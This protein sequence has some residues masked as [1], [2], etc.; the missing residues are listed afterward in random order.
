MISKQLETA[1]RS[2]LQ[3]ARKRRHE[4]LCAEHVL[5]ALLDDP[6]GRDIL[7]NVGVDIEKL[8]KDLDEYLSRQLD[9]VPERQ[10]LVVQQTVAFDRIMNRALMHAKFSS[11]GE[12]EA[13][14]ALAALLEESQSHAAFFLEEQGVTRLDV[15]N[16][17]SHGVSKVEDA[18]EDD[19]AEAPFGAPESGEADEK[20]NKRDPLELYT[21]NLA[22][23]AAQ[24]KIDPLIG[25]ETELARAVRVLCRRRKNNPVFVGEPGVGKTAIVEGLALRIHGGKVPP[26]LKDAEIFRLDLGALL[27]GTQFRGDLESRIKAVIK[28]LLKRDNV[29]LFI[30]EIH[31]VVGAGSTRG[32]DVDVSGLLKPLLSSGELKCIG[33]T[34]YEEYKNGFEKDRALARRFQKIDV[35]EPT[36]AET[37]QILRGLKS[38]YEAHHGITFTDSALHTAAE[39]AAKYVNDRFLPDKAIDVIDEAGAQVRIESHDQRKTIR[40]ADI[41]RIVA[42]M[43]RIPARS[44]SSNDK[45]RL[46]KLEDDLKQVVYGQ[47]DAVHSIATAIKRSRAGLSLPDKPVGSFLFTGPTG[48]GKTELAK[49]LASTLGID[50]IRFDMSEYMEE[51][52]ISKLIGSSRG[53]IGFELGGELTEQVRKHPHSVLLLDEIEK[54]HPK[55]FNVLL[56]IMDYGTLTDNAGRKADFRNII[57]VMTSNAGA[58]EMEQRTLGFRVDPDDAPGKSKKA[59]QRL[60][61]PEFRNRLD[62]IVNF[63][64]LPREVVLRIVHKFVAQ[65]GQRLA[66]RKVA[67]EITAPA[68]DFLADKGYDPKLGARPLARTIQ[69]E[70]EE[71]LAD[72]V[73]FGKL[74]K[75]GRVTVDVADGKLTF[76]FAA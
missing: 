46:A 50:F 74:S 21:D 5:F 75:G 45:E 15:L 70:L 32:S 14:D 33:A 34:T 47:D 62:T 67:I 63:G 55:I 27:A 68:A 60:F 11:K 4:Y 2:A 17:I 54:A 38:H 24:G 51:Y 59:I 65:L 7:E 49:Q 16:Y 64:A 61:T 35:V 31:M 40:P 25:R 28:A 20:K 30:D 13:G 9:Q 10:R 72:E 66:D 12:V 53:Y 22:K 48:V 19:A 44:V 69:R 52:T 71:P 42:E 23:R 26:L 8:R 39:L 56:Q 73:L 57:L 36:V 3:E 18:D 58:R 6:V 41:E 43:A 29:I 76:S 37:Y 1:L